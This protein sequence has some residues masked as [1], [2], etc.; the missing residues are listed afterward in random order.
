MH[1]CES[2]SEGTS[3]WLHFLSGWFCRLSS[4]G[5]FITI[6]H[7]LTPSPAHLATRPP[8]LTS[9][10]PIMHPSS[11]YHPSLHPLIHP[12]THLPSIYPSV[13][14]STTP[15]STHLLA[16]QPSTHSPST[17]P[18]IHPSAHH[19]ST[20]PSSIHPPSPLHLPIHQAKHGVRLR[21][22]G[23]R[24]CPWSMGA[25]SDSDHTQF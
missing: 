20:Y 10:P 3:V 11:I 14:A 18:S 4:D 12:S 21:T 7:S 1:P 13:H 2:R 25:Q 16:T 24:R 9:P 17:T 22:Q 6:I 5:V 23:Q 8:A 19:P 15:S